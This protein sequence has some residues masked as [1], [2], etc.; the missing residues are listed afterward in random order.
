MDKGFNPLGKI[1]FNGILVIS[2]AL[3]ALSCNKKNDSIIMQDAQ[4][5]I[6]CNLDD[7]KKVTNLS[8]VFESIDVIPLE[9][10]HLV[11][12]VDKIHSDE[13]GI[14]LANNNMLY[15]YNWN[16]Q[17]LF[18]LDRKG[19][20]LSDYLEI[21]D[22][23]L[24]EKY[25]AISDPEGMKILLFDKR[26]GQYDK[27]IQ[28]D[29]YPEEI[30]FL[31]ET[32]LMVNCGGTDGF[33]LV[34]LD[35]EKGEVTDG[36]FNFD[37]IFTEPLLQAFS[38]VNGTPLYRIPFYS[39]FYSVSKERKL[40]KALSFDFQAKNF[41]ANDLKT[42]NIMGFNMLTDSK[43]NANI[44]NMYAVNSTF[45]INFQC[46]SISEDSQYLL[47]VDTLNQTKYLFDSETTN[48]DILFYNHLA[49]PLFY[50]CNKDGFI[51]L[52]YPHLW[53]STFD[54]IDE[55]RK[56]TANYRKAQSIFQTVSKTDNPSVLVYRLK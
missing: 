42:I 7:A 16:G 14:Y 52:L 36:Y 26:D 48:D 6:D 49:L 19:R 1:V 40:E 41:N 13:S 12:F 45:A 8:D 23:T 20:A 32:T 22:F 30:A 11:G 10:K 54:S 35:I 29:F 15:A 56:N 38:S 27:T 2:A 24:S 47:L 43:G 25:I 9:E 28:V 53:A 55:E 50:D 37:R 51:C 46:Q 5:V 21:E 34:T 31:N 44:T 33:R 4:R 3:S 39:D 18:C 17:E